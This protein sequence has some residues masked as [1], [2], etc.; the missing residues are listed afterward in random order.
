MPIILQA[1]CSARAVT[2]ATPVAVL[3]QGATF[4]TDG[5]ALTNVA[6]WTLTVTTDHDVNVVISLAAGPNAGLVPVAGLATTVTAA[7][8]LY[9]A[10]DVESGQRLY[11]T[12]QAVST[13]AA[14][15]ADFRGVSQ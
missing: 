10:Q 13:T 12:A 3:G 1:G 4:S 2:S 14:V 6:K 11:V 7:A 15:S 5:I 9:I 8:P